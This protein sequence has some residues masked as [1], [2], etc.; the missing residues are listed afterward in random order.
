MCK[1]G[2]FLLLVINYQRQ[3]RGQYVPNSDEIALIVAKSYNH[4][5]SFHQLK[6]FLVVS[7]FAALVSLTQAHVKLLS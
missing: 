4:G 6:Y 7:N 3:R 2:L 1:I 5:R